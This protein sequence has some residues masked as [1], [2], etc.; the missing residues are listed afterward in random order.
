MSSVYSVRFLGE[1]GR[2]GTGPSFTV[3]PTMTAIVKF[4]T[5]YSSGGAFDVTGFLEDDLTGAALWHNDWG[6][7]S[8]PASYALYAGI[9]FEAG[10]GF[11]MQVDTLG[12]AG[13]DYS[14]SGYLLSA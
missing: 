8:G 12:T 6:A 4:A 1:A 13:I 11:H 14:V 7:T 9:V 2:L 10:S 5:M 3:P